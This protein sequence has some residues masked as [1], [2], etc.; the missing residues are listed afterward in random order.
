MGMM[1][2]MM[3]LFGGGSKTKERVVDQ[4][5]LPAKSTARRAASPP[6]AVT[7]RI[8][9]A[10]APTLDSPAIKVETKL[11]KPVKPVESTPTTPNRPSTPQPDNQQKKKKKKGFKKVAALNLPPG[12][13]KWVSAIQAPIQ[14][15]ETMMN[16]EENMDTEDI[17][18]RSQ[19][20]SL[21]F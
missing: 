19:Q 1:N 4:A 13:G 2:D 10:S 21:S 17:E 9:P 20:H 16:A 11:A 15:I 18:A 8:P 14:Q 6:K 5:V 7:P 12:V 3:Q